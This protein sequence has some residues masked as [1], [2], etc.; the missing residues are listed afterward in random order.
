MLS[1]WLLGISGVENREMDVKEVIQE[2][3]RFKGHEFPD[4]STFDHIDPKVEITNMERYLRAFWG[5]WK[6]KWLVKKQN[7]EQ[8]KTEQIIKW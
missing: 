7:T 6:E 4:W 1:Q 5:I 8:N 3:F 2:I